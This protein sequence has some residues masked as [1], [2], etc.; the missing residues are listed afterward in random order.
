MSILPGF[1]T[2]VM[3]KTGGEHPDVQSWYTLLEV[4]GKPPSTP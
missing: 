3:P 2:N 1:V 4:P